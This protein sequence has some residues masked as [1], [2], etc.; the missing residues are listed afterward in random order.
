M[1]AMLRRLLL[2]GL[3]CVASAQAQEQPDPKR[4]ENEILRFEQQDRVQMPPVGG[5]VLT[6]SSSIARWGAQAHTALA[7]LT[8]VSRGFG[9]STMHDLVHY[10]DRVALVYKPRAILIYEGDND[11]G[12]DPPVRKEAIVADLQQIIARIHAG[13]PQARIYVLSIKPSLLRRARWGLAQE[14]NSAYRQIAAAD[15]L[16]H[17]VDVAAYLQ[18]KD[19][20]VMTDLFVGDGL[21]LNELGNAI[22]GAAIKAALMPMEARVEEGTSR[23]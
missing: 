22:W 10:L 11:T 9:G 12:A 5:I 7:P 1:T 17:Y 6:G 4:F 3:A 19:G 15:P 14:V 16:V 8:V 21:H 23:Q 13:L 20:S 2:I 18:N